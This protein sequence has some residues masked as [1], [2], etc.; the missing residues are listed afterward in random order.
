MW[1]GRDKELPPWAL[2]RWEGDAAQL[3]E[4]L[5]TSAGPAPMAKEV[6][7]PTTRRS[8]TST[9][10]CCLAPPSPLPCCACVSAPAPATGP[11]PRAHLCLSLHCSQSPDTPHVLRPPELWGPAAGCSSVCQGAGCKNRHTGEKPWS[12]QAGLPGT[13][14]QPK[15]HPLPLHP[16]SILQALLCP[17]PS[18]ISGSP[19]FTPVPT[20]PGGPSSTPNGT[21]AHQVPGKGMAEESV[22]LPSYPPCPQGH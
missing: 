20:W 5:C 13:L 11:L 9:V 8:C 16:T 18:P 17:R 21:S 22:T 6:R 19:A 1:F 4:G 12:R 14:V 2:V 7:M 3:R 15:N 10:S